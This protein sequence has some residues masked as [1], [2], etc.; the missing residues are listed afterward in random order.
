ML[1]IDEIS[2]VTNEEWVRLKATLKA[3]EDDRFVCSQCQLKDKHL[4]DY[5]ERNHRLRE[6]KACFSVSKV[7]YHHIDNEIGFHTCIGNFYSETC[8]QWISIYDNYARGVLPFPGSL[9]EQPT[10][11][12]EI[13]RIVDDYKVRKEIRQLESQRSRDKTKGAPLGR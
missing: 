1:K 13:F 3:V 8:H 5:K 12:M 9:M 6:S 4:P 7:Q 11:A 2:S 10:K